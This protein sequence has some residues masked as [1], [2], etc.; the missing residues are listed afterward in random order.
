MEK[1]YNWDLNDL[2][3]NKTLDSLYKNWCENYTKLIELYNDGKCYENIEDLESYLSFREVSSGLENRL[4]N[5][6]SNKSNE[7]LS[8]STFLNW[9]QK[10]SNKLSEFSLYFANEINVIH[11]NK[12]TIEMFLNKNE[13]NYRYKRVFDLVFRE[14]NHRISDDEEKIITKLSSSLSTSS[15]VFNMLTESEI[16]LLPI[17]DKDGQIKK[18]STISDI[19]FILE[20]STD[21]ELRKNAL[22]SLNKSYSR[23]EKTLTI[24]LYQNFLTLNEISKIYNHKNYIYQVCWNDEIE[25]N[26]I[27]HVYKQVKNYKDI[28]KDFGSI[29]EKYRKKVMGLNKIE[30]WDRSFDIYSNRKKFTISESQKIILKALSVF[31]KE[32][33]SIVKKAFDENWISW[34]SSKN[35]MSGAYTIG[36][37]K[38]LN[39]YYILMNFDKTFNSILTASHELGHALNAYY[40]NKEQDIYYENEIFD[41][42]IPST[43]NEILVSLYLLKNNKDNHQMVLKIYYEL[44]S[45]FFSS[46][47]RQLMFSYTEKSIIDM[48]DNNLPVDANEI[49]KIYANSYKFFMGLSDKQ[50]KKI[51]TR[52]NGQDLSLIFRISHF[53]DGTF[54]VYKYSIGMIIGI[55]SAIKIFEGDKEFLDKYFLFLSTGSSIKS[56]DKIKLLGFDL[57][58]S[59]VWLKAKRIIK[60]WIE[61]YKKITNHAL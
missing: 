57:T 11:N 29:E 27:D 8:N 42:E 48:I 32:Y 25:T 56:I 37:T 6:I 60:K 41:A 34:L 38:G 40:S 54:Y 53:Y 51:L 52:N 22:Y 2:L 46:T 4:L 10:L 47:T 7:D 3:D 16:G 35:K 33:T 21:R 19:D 1:K 50:V 17:K 59:D 14:E 13:S 39:K 45:N 20:N 24:T 18:V 26:F 58:K 12:N 36:N 44:I 30:S 23:F 43:V 5:Y 49:K 55:L 15:L 31:G 28:Y 9:D 61:E